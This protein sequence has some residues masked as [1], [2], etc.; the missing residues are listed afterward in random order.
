MVRKI[1]TTFTEGLQKK[2]KLCRGMTSLAVILSLGFFSTTQ[3]NA[4]NNSEVEVVENRYLIKIKTPKDVSLFEKLLF[5]AQNAKLLKEQIE[6][7]GDIIRAL[8]LKEFGIMNVQASAE[9]IKRLTQNNPNIDYV[10]PVVR[11]KTTA[12][13]NEASSLDEAPYHEDALG[14]DS[15]NPSPDEE[16]TF[17][18]SLIVAV[19]DTG[20]NTEHPYLASA[21][22]VNQA[23]AKGSPGVDDDNNG[24]I[25]DID[26]IN[27]INNSGNVEDE[28]TDH[29]THVAS[30]VKSVRDQAI[31]EYPVAQKV[32]ILPI[33]FI[34]GN[35]QG[36]TSTA[37]KGLQYAHNRGAKV[38]NCSWGALGLANYSQ[39]LYD[40]MVDL[41]LQDVLI[42]AAAGN[43]SYNDNND[44][45]SVPF[46]PS[47]FTRG[48]PGFISV[49]SV[50]PKYS[51]SGSQFESIE[52]SKFSNFG[53][54]SVDISAPGSMLNGSFNIGLRGANADFS[55]SSNLFKSKEGTSMAAPLVA[56]VAGVIRAINPSLTN[57]EVK[58][59]ILQSATSEE[60]LTDRSKSDKVLHASNALS[61]A[62]SSVSTGERPAYDSNPNFT[63]DDQSAT[64][65][66]NNNS[67]SGGSSGGGGCGAITTGETSTNPLGG[68]GLLAALM[69][70]LVLSRM[71]L[72]V[73]AGKKASCS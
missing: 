20:M 6:N 39:A 23:E 21:R 53:K 60:K 73:F 19:I 57:Y 63:E 67:N 7:S 37:I 48:I 28:G 52:F 68:N 30:L 31:S 56:G 22:S 11:W 12:Y 1:T 14:F 40:I 38:I 43:S 15:I 50:S 55:S 32:E 27:A 26:G 25:D 70:L 49:G 33:R 41:Y 10:E 47:S 8:H 65:S 16:N 54:K 5:R 69:F 34:D 24:Y 51:V 66:T 3:S 17:S 58:K 42:V 44:N 72:K 61:L 71:D 2:K 59:I 45:D 18:D 64:P 46:F 9:A 36:S 13:D 62:L 29:G 35:G 4:S